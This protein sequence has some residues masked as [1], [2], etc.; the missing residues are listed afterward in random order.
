MASE[1]ANIPGASV[2]RY[3]RDEARQ[4]RPLA[5]LF[6]GV[7]AVLTILLVAG[8]VFSFARHGSPPRVSLDVLEEGEKLLAAGEPRAA[9]AEFSGAVAIVPASAQY[10]VSLGTVAYAT[11]DRGTAMRA[12]R[13]ALRYDASHPEAGY[14]L[15]VLYLQDGRAAEAVELISRAAPRLQGS[16]AAA[17]YSD[18]GVAY[19]RTGDTAQAME[20]Y[21]QALALEPGFAAARKNLDALERRTQ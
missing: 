9:V 5:W 4:G 16:Q 10:Q 11:G 3:A 2:L 14:F 7:A 15:G 13:Q 8:F 1:L 18:L 20:S 12:F 17:A 19:A 21:R 6:L